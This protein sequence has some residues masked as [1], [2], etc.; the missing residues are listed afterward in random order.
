MTNELRRIKDA[1]EC[2]LLHITQ[3]ADIKK[4]SNGWEELPDMVQNMILELSAIQDDILPVE[5]CE[6]YLKV[7]KQAKI[8]GVTMVLNLE[9]RLQKCQVDIPTTMINAIKTGNFQANSFLVAHS[10]SIFNVPFMNATNMTS[11]YK[12]ELNILDEGEQIPKD[13]SK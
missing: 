13:I 6:S 11:C 2:Q 8:L 12:T 4:E 5:P 9:L 10:F 3:T 7:L 1:A